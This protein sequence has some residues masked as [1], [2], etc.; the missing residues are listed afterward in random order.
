M[1][2]HTR[3]TPLRVKHL[4]I[5]AACL[6][7]IQTLVAPTAWAQTAPGGVQ[8]ITVSTSATET[9]VRVVVPGSHGAIVSPDDP[10]VKD[11]ALAAPEAKTRLKLF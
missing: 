5:Q 7:A 2:L 9:V 1:K 11:P 8:V 3:P 4:I 10:G 6:V